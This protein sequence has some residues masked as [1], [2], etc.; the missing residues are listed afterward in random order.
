[1]NI[2]ADMQKGFVL[3]MT[4]IVLALLTV[5]SMGLS[6]MARSHI[7]DVQ[8]RSDLFN[9]GLAMKSRAQWVLYHLLTGVP[10]KRVFRTG[11]FELPVDATPVA[12]SDMTIRVQDGAGLLGLAVF[13]PF[14]FESLLKKLLPRQD[15]SILS[16][17]LG[18]WLDADNHV[19]YQGMEEAD[20]VSAGLSVRPRNGALRSVDELLEIPGFTAE[21]YNGVGGQQGLRDLLLAGG[22]VH[23]NLATAPEILIGPVLGVSGSELARIISLRA[24]GAWQQLSQRVNRNPVFTE[25]FSPFAP[26]LLF[27]IRVRALSGMSLRAIY[28]LEPYKDVP[29]RLVLWQYPDYER[30]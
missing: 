4:L 11:A 16:A 22:E 29:Y 3:P 14:V 28:I 27:Q 19:R 5:L 7:R 2:Q 13:K 18:D 12:S 9:Q 23:F 21:L 10:E 30:G 24:K 8:L 25:D 15:A 1:M 26:G 17:R 20:Y 6:Q